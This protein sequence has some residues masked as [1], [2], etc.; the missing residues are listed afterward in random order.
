[1]K[2]I[3]HYTFIS[4]S[5]DAG[6]IFDSDQESAALILIMS[7]RLSFLHKLFPN[8]KATIFCFMLK[9]IWNLNDTSSVI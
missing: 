4:K 7:S 6:P 1:M 2:K 3:C 5:F 9:E 8:A